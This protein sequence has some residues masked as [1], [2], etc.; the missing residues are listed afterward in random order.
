MR[1]LHTADWHLGRTLEGRSRQEEHEAFV[2]ELCA[3]V[4]EER[5]DLVLIAGDVFDTGNPSAAAE[6]LYCDALAR[7]G[8]NGRRAVVVIA[9]NHDSPDRLTAVQALAQRHGATMFGYPYDDPGVY[10]PGPDRVQRVAAGPGWAELTVPGVDHSAVVLAL[11]YPSESRLRKL[12]ADTLGEEELQRSYSDQ[13]KGWLAAAAGRFR[14]DAVRLVTSHLYMAGGVES[15]VVERPIQM[16]GAYT[17]HPCAVPETAQYVALGHLHRPQEIHGTAAVTRYSGSPIS[18]SFNETGYV[19]GV[20]VVEVEP[21]DPAPRVRHVPISAGRPLVRWVAEDG[22]AQ[23]E[24]W[25][26]EGKD[27]TAWISLEVHTEHPLT[28]EQVHRLRA[29]RPEFVHIRAV[30]PAEAEAAATA[31]PQRLGVDEQFVRFYSQ[32]RGGPPAPELVRLFL[33]LVNARDEEVDA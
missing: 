14:P 25:V 9:G 15:D 12:I 16:G 17:V 4:R 23:V 21:R 6:E 28:L 33:E 24:R 22:L 32:V 10:T 27:P 30:L 26:A 13:V 3:M 31:E 1:I 7:L 18:F 8:E 19:K 2:D 11:P 5:I 20:T 29:M